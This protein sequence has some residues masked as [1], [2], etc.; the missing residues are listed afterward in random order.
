MPWLLIGAVAAYF[1]LT[2]KGKAEAEEA[3]IVVP[4][5]TPEEKEQFQKDPNKPMAL[6]ALVDTKMMQI[7]TGEADPEIPVQTTPEVEAPPPEAGGVYKTYWANGNGNGAAPS[8]FA[9]YGRRY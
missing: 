7:A 4:P 1:L 3:V 8:S 5:V 9:D 2:K 6:K